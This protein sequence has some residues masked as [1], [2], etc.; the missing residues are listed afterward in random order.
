MD[1]ET[2]YC[3]GGMGEGD[4]HDSRLVNVCQTGSKK[5]LGWTRSGRRD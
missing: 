2:V 3:F 4:Y 1:G 5:V